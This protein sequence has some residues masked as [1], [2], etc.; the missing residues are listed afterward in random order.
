MTDHIS[1]HLFQESISLTFEKE[2]LEATPQSSIL[3]KSGAG[4]SV[5]VVA[6][7]PVDTSPKKVSRD[8]FSTETSCELTMSYDQQYAG[9][10]PK[11]LQA[12]YCAC[13]RRNRLLLCQSLPRGLLVNRV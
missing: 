2:W 12:R 4:P 7:V 1:F 5:E 13:R 10:S 8:F 3:H 11:I 6:L 9:G